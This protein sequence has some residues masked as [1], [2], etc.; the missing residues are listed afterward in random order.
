M[1]T[2]TEW[3]LV[4]RDT[5]RRRLSE[6][7]SGRR[8][9]PP[10]VISGPAGVGK[11]RFM[12]EALDEVAAAGSPVVRVTGSAAASTIPFGAVAHLLPDELAGADHLT[13]LRGAFRVLASTAPGD[14]TTAVLG[15]DDAHL[16][17]PGSAAVVQRAV[18]LTPLRVALTVR[19]G[20][21]APD[22]IER[23]TTDPA[24]ERI[25]LDL[26]T[27]E[28]I[29]ALLRHALAGPVTGTTVHRLA[30]LSEGNPLWLRE[31]VREARRRETLVRRGGA[32]R[33][34]GSPVHDAS[35]PDAL[36]TTMAGLDP[37]V[38]DVV[39]VVALSDVIGVEVLERLFGDDV[40]EAADVQGLLMAAPDRRRMQ[41]RLA[42]PLFGEAVLRQVPPLRARRLRLRL[43][44]AVEATGGRRRGDLLRMARWRLDA[45]DRS[46]PGLLAAA[47]VAVGTRPR[48]EIAERFARAAID[49][50]AGVG[51]RIVLAEAQQW[52]GRPDEA[53]EELLAV[54]AEA[55]S[56]EL[57]VHAHDLRADALF[58][59]GH[60][61]EAEDALNAA[62]SAAETAAARHRIAVRRAIFA[63]GTGD[64][65]YAVAL[66]VD[67]LGEPSIAVRVRQDAAFVVASAA[68]PCGRPA[69]AIDVIDEARDIMSGADGVQEPGCL[70]ARALACSWAWRFDE[71]EAS[72]EA[73]N[74]A[75]PSVVLM[76]WYRGVV[77][78]ASGRVGRARKLLAESVRM[79]Q[80]DIP[81]GNS[82]TLAQHSSALSEAAALGGDRAA[83]AERLAEADAA[84]SP[85]MLIPERLSA[86][87]WVTAAHGELDTARSH[88]VEGADAAREVGAHLLEARLWHDLVRL[89]DAERAAPR[90]E[91][92]APFID[93]AQGPLYAAHARGLA[94][95][96]ATSVR[97]AAVGFEAAGVLLLAAEAHA[98]LAK[99]L[100]DEGRAV[101]ATGAQLASRR[102]ADQCEG[103]RTRAL[104]LASGLDL[105]DRELE[106]AQMAAHG[107]SDREIADQL[108]IS[109]RTV[110]THLHR[111]YTKLGIDRR[112]DLSDL[113]G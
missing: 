14:G 103:A 94:D 62:E 45:G 48:P 18:A 109:L 10:A 56:S 27:E 87:V 2:L 73:A 52:S 107:L 75:G 79:L 68:P 63:L 22:V 23:L 53:A 101:A 40:L 33:L 105:T 50:G 28:Q 112:A 46:R 108:A 71:V 90:L 43:A 88:A 26:L 110:N 44:D 11:T 25:A 78:L 111:C 21:Q 84:W 85:D 16:L 4:G 42:H 41:V 15:V 67:A 1:D 113:I 8:G 81:G 74:A 19:D 29:G 5:A 34:D 98:Q 6:A 95:S 60:P 93:S 31:L 102:L 7:F 38:R 69:W 35:L 47:A 72:I 99:L 3:P 80:R 97:R 82:D 9:A 91:Q 37:E 89:G 61:A 77:A 96:D 100:H 24:T 51:T 32:W 58:W 66:A 65:A 17:D 55:T 86:R 70:H 64:L 36:R 59:S 54:A 92:L 12:T 104:A 49:A 83:A 13:I 57:V 20:E 76:S 30:H 106:I 39:A